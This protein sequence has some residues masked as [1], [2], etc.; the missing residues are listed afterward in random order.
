MDD[1]RFDKLIRALHPMAGS[2]RA[3]T[4]LLAGLSLPLIPALDAHAL[5]GK[6]KRQNKRKH[7]RKRTAK[8]VDPAVRF[9]ESLA[10]E[11]QKV[12]GDCDALAQAAEDF[13]QAHLAEF[14]ELA[15]R[16]EQL[17]AETRSRLAKKH[18][19]R[20]TQATETLH[21]LMASCR[22]RGTSDAPICEAVGG[23]PV[24]LPGEPQCGTGCD[25]SC[26][27]PIS[28]WDCTLTFFACLGG[29]E[30]SCCWFGACAGN[31]CAEQCPNCCNCNVNCC[32]C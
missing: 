31:Q 2:R 17:D 29:S 10:A 26:I 22:F 11:M 8:S 25:C 27:C 23:E 4:A 28:S 13:K 1:Q 18:Q 12:G 19:A 14:N 6:R 24:T 3:L 30:A 20:I 5:R 16:Q 9:F 21:T 15:D 32:G 7:A